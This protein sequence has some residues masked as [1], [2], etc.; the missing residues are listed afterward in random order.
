[1]KKYFKYVDRRV[2]AILVVLFLLMLGLNRTWVRS[3]GNDLAAANN[4]R[5]VAER[6]LA[7][8]R[9][10][11]SEARTSGIT[12]AQALLSRVGRLEA[13]LPFG[14]NDITLT[15]VFVG[16]AESSGVQLELFEL[17]RSEQK[18]AD[19]ETDA[20]ASGDVTGTRAFSYRFKVSGSYQAVNSFLL[21]SVS[22]DTLIVSLEGLTLYSASKSEQ[23]SIFDDLVTAEG[24]LLIWTS[25]ERPLES[26][27]TVTAD[28]ATDATEGNDAPAA[29]A[30]SDQSQSDPSPSPT[31][32]APQPG[33]PEPAPPAQQPADSAEA[34]P[35]PP[36]DDAQ[37]GTADP[38]AAPSP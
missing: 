32:S 20:A 36:A 26:G 22:S 35:Q 31:P 33:A 18:E 27:V 25:L 3:V 30:P 16:V 7:D 34:E 9:S 37:A 11:L 15:Q 17:V 21:A 19:A 6:E 1:V 14:L 29:Q 10:R 8:L 2:A 4:D 24:T 23:P 38:A 28:G 13:L 12:G 5:Q